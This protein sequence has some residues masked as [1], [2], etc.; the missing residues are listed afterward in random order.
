MKTYW[1]VGSEGTAPHILNPGTRW[2][3]VVS[4]MPWPLYTQG[5]SAWYTLDRRLGRPQKRDKEK[6]PFPA[7]ARNQIPIIL[8]PA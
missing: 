1:E 7:H 3:Q 4:F 8:P 5:K 6:N 2:R